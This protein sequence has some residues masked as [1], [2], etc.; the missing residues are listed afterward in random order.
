MRLDGRGP[1]LVATKD[2]AV[3]LDEP[4]GAATAR[5]IGPTYD[6]SAGG[7]AAIGA[8][9]TTRGAIWPGPSDEIVNRSMR[10]GATFNEEDGASLDGLVRIDTTALLVVRYDEVAGLPP[11]TSVDRVAFAANASRREV[12][13]LDA[14]SSTRAPRPLGGRAPLR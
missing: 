7:F 10:G 2:R 6:P 3:T 14:S 5:P 4:G 12:W 11:G 13:M 9:E 8:D 1:V